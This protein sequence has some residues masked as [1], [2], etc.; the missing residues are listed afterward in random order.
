M[1][2]RPGFTQQDAQLLKTVSSGS[3]WC[4]YLRLGCPCRVVRDGIRL[5]WQG[6]EH[7]QLLREACTGSRWAHGPLPDRCVGRRECREVLALHLEKCAW[8]SLFIVL[9][10]LEWG[11]W[12][13][14]REMAGASLDIRRAYWKL[15]PR[16]GIPGCSGKEAEWFASS[17]CFIFLIIEHLPRRR[18]LYLRMAENCR[19]TIRSFT[20]QLWWGGAWLQLP[21]FAQRMLVSQWHPRCHEGLLPACLPHHGP[22]WNK[23]LVK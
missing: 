15:S 13:C 14:F 16:E 5:I 12:F 9:G 2:G 8:C 23:R 1:T 3:S 19:S 10:M 11:C 4:G 6:L 21:P 7:C 17:I 20:G 18:V 22:L